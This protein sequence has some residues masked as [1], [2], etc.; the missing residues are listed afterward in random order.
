MLDEL[1][2]SYHITSS[3][4]L[5]VPICLGF[6]LTTDTQYF[7][8]F[9]LR[10]QVINSVC[11]FGALFDDD[12]LYFPLI[13]RV[14]LQIP[15]IQ[16][17]YF[18]LACVAQSLL[19]FLTLLPRLFSWILNLLSLLTFSA[20]MNFKASSVPLHLYHSLHYLCSAAP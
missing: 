20:C 9:P 8:L 13:F 17:V 19:H 4:S 10:Q 11:Q 12:I 16:K 14:G 18:C 15:V 1:I 2:L 5:E 6:S 3:S 7:I